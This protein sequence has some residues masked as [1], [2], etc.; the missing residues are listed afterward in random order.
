MR[1]QWRGVFLCFILALCTAASGGSAFAVAAPVFTITSVTPDVVL[2][3]GD[4]VNLRVD[5]AVTPAQ[6][7]D[8][9]S[10]S[11]WVEATVNGKLIKSDVQTG[12]LSSG[13][14]YVLLYYQAP[15]LMCMLGSSD[16]NCPS[17][18]PSMLEGY[19]KITELRLVASM[20]G[21]SPKITLQDTE[22][23]K[24][25][26]FDARI[27]PNAQPLNTLRTV[28]VTI[29]GA[30]FTQAL[31]PVIRMVKSGN[32]FGCGPNAGLP[33]AGWTCA[34]GTTFAYHDPNDTIKVL[35]ANTFEAKWNTTTGASPYESEVNIESQFVG[36]YDMLVSW[37]VTPTTP[38]LSQRNLSA[39]VAKAF[40]M[41]AP[42]KDDALTVTSI[43]G[44]VVLSPYPNYR[45]QSFTWT[46][47]QQFPMPAAGQTSIQIDRVDGT[48]RLDRYAQAQIMVAFRDK[49]TGTVSGGPVAYVT[50]TFEQ[51]HAIW[52]TSNGA[53][54]AAGKHD[55]CTDAYFAAGQCLM[56][57]YL[58]IPNTARSNLDLVAILFPA[59]EEWNNI[60]NPIVPRIK[61][62][63]V[64]AQ[65]DLAITRVA[66]V[67]VIHSATE[68]PLIAGR[69][70][71]ARVFIKSLGANAQ[72][73]AGV[74]AVLHGPAGRDPYDIRLTGPITAQP[75]NGPMPPNDPPD[76]TEPTIDFEL[77]A[78]WVRV[79]GGFD[80][81]A[82]IVP[83][84]G[85]QDTSPG[86]NTLKRVVALHPQPQDPL[87]L[88]PPGQFRVGFVTIDHQPPGA[89]APLRVTAGLNTSGRFMRTLFPLAPG[90]L[91]YQRACR[92][93][94]PYREPLASM[95]DGDA[96]RNRLRMRFFDILAASNTTFDQL[97]AFVPLENDNPAWGAS[98]A[99]WG[100]GFGD[101]VVVQE[102]QN[103]NNEDRT[104]AHEIGHNLGLRH[105]T[106]LPGKAKG[107]P[108]PAGDDCGIA[109]VPGTPPVNSPFWPYEDPTIQTPGYDV[110]RHALVPAGNFDFMSYCY[111]ATGSNIWVSPAYFQK[112]FDNKLAPTEAPCPPL[113]K[114]E[115]SQAREC[116]TSLYP[117]TSRK[118]SEAAQDY[119]IVSGK[120]SA[121]GL[122]GR[123]NPAFRLSTRRM[124]PASDPNGN[125]CV[126]FLG[127]SPQSDYCFTLSFTTP[128]AD[129]LT[130]ESFSFPLAVPSGATGFALMRGSAQLAS[131]SG[132]G[133]APSV[134]I[135]APK[136]GDRWSSDQ[137]ITWSGTG[138]AP[139]T[140]IVDY[141]FDGG[142]TW[143][144]LTFDTADTS[145][146]VSPGDFLGPQV[147]FRVQASDGFNTG[148]DQ[149]GPVNVTQTPQIKVLPGSVDFPNGLVSTAVERELVLTNSGTGPLQ[150]SSIG[151]T[152][153][154]FA[155]VSPPL[156][157]SIF[158]GDSLALRVRFTPPA[159]VVRSGNMTVVSNAADVPSL[160]VPLQGRGVETLA[161]EAAVSSTAVDFG[162]VPRDGA[163][164]ADIT[165]RNLGP[166][167][168]NVMNFSVTGTGF[169]TPGASGAFTVDSDGSKALSVQFVAS[170]TLGVQTGSIVIKTDDPAHATIT[171]TLRA[172][173]VA[174]GPGNPLP[175][176][177]SGG[178]VNAASFD[179]LLS[180]GAVAT[181]F[182]AE[183]AGATGGAE[184][185]PL[186]R[187]LFGTRVIVAGMDAPLFYT[188]PTQIN[189]QV[190][191]ET[192]LGSAEVRVV[193]DGI[194]SA[195]ATVNI[196]DY[197]PGVFTYARTATSRDAVVVYAD[198][199]LVTP[200]RPASP[201][202][203]LI[204]YATGI[205]LLSSL[206]A[207]G[208]RSPL[209]LLISAKTPPV[210]TLGGKP[211]EVVFAGLT[212]G[213]IGLAQF[214]VRLPADL[215]QG[216]YL[217][218]IVKFG[219]V[220]SPPVQLPVRDNAPPSAGP[221]IDI[222]PA[223]LDFGTVAIG[224]SKDLPLTIRNTGGGMLNVSAMATGDVQFT[225][226][227]SPPPFS[228]PA[229]GM[230]TVTIRFAPGW[231]GP[232][233]AYLTISSDDPAKSRTTVTLTGSGAPLSQAPKIVVELD[234]LDFG[235]VV[236]GR[237]MDRPFVIRNYGGA[238]LDVSAI[239]TSSPQY[240]VYLPPTPFS[241]LTGQVKGV[242]LRF[243]PAAVGPQPASLIIVSN[244]PAT[245][246]LTLPM[247]GSGTAAPAP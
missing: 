218:L 91:V 203:V 177:A 228:V 54:D 163:K 86:N 52:D 43:T 124:P 222:A 109:K 51:I 55:F 13:K 149:V 197:A 140:Y 181:V 238:T 133:Q 176:V 69:T 139:L 63:D 141:S 242:V 16:K 129:A 156:P 58:Q 47:G 98:D 100:G 123:L 122:S 172:E 193:R 5:M 8:G 189:F 53:R 178:V 72:P 29:P 234:S 233:L 210:I 89:A 112:L 78:D 160:V 214:N 56:H 25:A 152:D 235:A 92:I 173:V 114:P 209:S 191:F 49:T 103:Q 170:Q 68:V 90:G 186:P 46:P 81:T 162:K 12:S 168:L 33:Y 196:A 158:A 66:L 241:I 80:F 215:P 167:V 76:F 62:A 223:S 77:P 161:P 97:V 93:R 200:S 83:P 243:I 135:T 17:N 3:P 64:G 108:R 137:T 19:Q 180:R 237:S 85:F 183:L 225:I 94:N 84:A 24:F 207:T 14:G 138:S 67:Q 206:P 198:N 79:A 32:A 99:L 125:Y 246:R 75:Y 187:T 2:A 31:R 151:F 28:R 23:L 96:L 231:V 212:P 144:P 95:A 219:D 221:A 71:I 239:T 182:G 10:V 188:S 21:G 232:Q 87:S 224:Q 134:K 20:T 82:E 110:E 38:G 42:L 40:T 27:S 217:P 174:A 57:G 157:F 166:A 204:I 128:D 199:A 165:V 113:K 150:V 39:F 1:T 6:G 9:S 41:Q 4:R 73:V 169:S 36:A 216:P 143:V 74:T 227:V 171:I 226:A 116:T 205:G 220:A 230:Q 208:D 26:E 44:K 48:F 121:D 120:A 45:E 132:A 30:G 154:S 229:G 164:T 213:S 117:E 37:S 35:D 15:S 184:S 192:A 145:V 136:A 247:T 50:N 155:L 190:P 7:Y 175:T 202:D 88:S 194:I 131:I 142:V 147:Y 115:A 18:P 102:G 195:A 107:C 101:V 34:T 104:V 245:P 11:V 159:A 22:G 65:G 119:M 106:F 70:T 211:V 61:L 127:G 146:S 111:N 240:T 60:Q 148:T 179:P 118:L 130:E 244:D 59:H 153:A 185:V 126:R 236:L 105:A 201:G